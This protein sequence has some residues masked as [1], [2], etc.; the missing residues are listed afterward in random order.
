MNARV[1]IVSLSSLL[2]AAVALAAQP[3]WRA[4]RTADGHPDLQGVWTSATIT[5]LERPD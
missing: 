5:P 2:V 4:P 3:A 1:L